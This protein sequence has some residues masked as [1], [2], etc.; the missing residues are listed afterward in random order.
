MS[1][2]HLSKR[3]GGRIAFDDV[4]FKVGRGEVFGFLG[5]NGAGK[6]TTVRA[7]GTLIAPSS[8]SA[9]VAGIAL[10]PDRR[11]AGLEAGAQLGGAALPVIPGVAEEEVPALRVRHR[12]LG[13]FA[14]DWL[15]GPPLRGRVCD[16]AASPGAP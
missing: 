1:A 5:P 6:T 14:G 15:D 8:G 13:G 3:F 4:T 10:E 11:T 7:L 16:R 12:L 9:T 2:D